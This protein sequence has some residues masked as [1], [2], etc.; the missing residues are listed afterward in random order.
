MEMRFRKQP[1]QTAITPHARTDGVS[2]RRSQYWMQL[3]LLSVIGS[4]VGSTIGHVF[5]LMQAS[6]DPL[7]RIEH[8][9]DWL[10]VSAVVSVATFL[11]LFW[12]MRWLLTT[13][14]PAAAAL[15]R[16]FRSAPPFESWELN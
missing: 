9:Y 3:L 16:M 13:R 10:S 7:F 11:L 14:N 6:R 4:L 15:L 2:A 1:S 5:L 12:G 8:V